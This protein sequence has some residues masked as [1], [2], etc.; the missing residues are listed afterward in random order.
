MFTEFDE[1]FKLTDFK[2]NHYYVI[3][4]QNNKTNQRKYQTI[5]KCTFAGDVKKTNTEMTRKVTFDD[6]FEFLNEGDSEIIEDWS[7][8][9]ED[10]YGI[11][12]KEI[13]P[14]DYP[15]YFI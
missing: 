2:E 11:R 6:I 7:L 13:K 9:E 5:S 1:G 12:V 15:E 4:N 8:Y 10:F 14:K 3:D